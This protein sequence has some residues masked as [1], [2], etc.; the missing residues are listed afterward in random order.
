MHD[1]YLFVIAFSSGFVVGLLV[2][3]PPIGRLLIASSKQP[4]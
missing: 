3:I 1:F 2:T 4:A